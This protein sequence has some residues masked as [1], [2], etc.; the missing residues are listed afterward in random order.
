[1]KD[2]D[3]D[4][5]SDPNKDHMQKWFPWEVEV[6]AYHIDIHKIVGVS[7]SSIMIRVHLF[8]IQC[9]VPF[10][11]FSSWWDLSN[12]LVRNQN[13]DRMEKLCHN[14]VDVLAYYFRV[15]RTLLVSSSSFIFRVHDIWGNHVWDFHYYTPM[16]SFQQSL[17][18]TK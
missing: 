13:G 2:L 9:V 12:G 14:E 11:Y 7:Y 18:Q 5:S 10:Y 16:K 3:N 15:H 4:L 8:Q 6:L 1:M 17:E